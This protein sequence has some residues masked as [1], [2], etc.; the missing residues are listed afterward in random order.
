MERRKFMTALLKKD[1]TMVEACRQFG[2]SRKTGYKIVARTLAAAV[3]F[4]TVPL[5]PPEGLWTPLHDLVAAQ[6]VCVPCCTQTGREGRAEPTWPR[7]ARERTHVPAHQDLE[8]EQR[9]RVR[10]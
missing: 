6:A 3:P 7:P 2:I 8:G 4:Y 1:L 10:G 5:T 9:P